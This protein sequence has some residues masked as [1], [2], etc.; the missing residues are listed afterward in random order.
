MEICIHYSVV[1]APL[2]EE[3]AGFRMDQ[4]SPFGSDCNDI[5]K[6]VIVTAV[7]QAGLS[8]WAG[9]GRSDIVHGIGTPLNR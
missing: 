3:G 5:I 2:S 6:C 7:G 4:V 1:L 9:L 8:S